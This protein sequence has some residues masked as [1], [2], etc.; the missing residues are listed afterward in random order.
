MT[1]STLAAI[2]IPI[3]AMSALAAWIVVVFH[4]D[5]HPFWENRSTAAPDRALARP[6]RKI[7]ARSP[8][9][10]LASSGPRGSV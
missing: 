4:A 8:H 3:V 1:G 7:R 6:S 9:G 2:V 10:P 5:S